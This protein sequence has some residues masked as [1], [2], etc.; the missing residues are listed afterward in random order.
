[1]KKLLII[2]I[3][4]ASTVVFAQHDEAFVNAQLTHI[5]AELVK[6]QVPEYFVRK[7]YCE[8]NVQMF[9]MSD[10]SMCA[11]SSTYYSVYVFWRNEDGTFIQKIDNCGGFEKIKIVDSFLL[12]RVSSLKDQLQKE[13][14]KPYTT[15]KQ[16]L[17][18]F[19]NMTVE[20]CKKEFTFHFGELD[21]IKEFKEYDLSSNSKFPNVNA[22]YN[23]ELPLIQLDRDV[24]EIV[25]DL[26][27][28]RKFRRN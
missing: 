1:M 28:K 18:P 24:T 11:S 10:G 16:D 3:F 15:E 27:L 25:A 19:G 22:A 6:Q 12:D 4:V 17:S 14:V 20:D 26:E 7:D 5:K 21:F 8:G 9:K 13:D 23:N 2:F